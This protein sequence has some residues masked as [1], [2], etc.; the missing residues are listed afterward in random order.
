MNWVRA[1]KLIS[2]PRLRT[3]F[4]E[5]PRGEITQLA[6]WSAYNDAFAKAKLTRPLMQAKDFITNVS[7]TFT[8]AQ[9]RVVPNEQDPSR[10]K[11][12][13]GGVRPRAVPVD[14]RGRPY[15]RCLWRT[16]APST[17]GTT[18]NG[19]AHA[20]AKHTECDLSV[21]KPEELWDHV[22]TAH[23][24]VPKDPTTGKFSLP[25]NFAE[26]NPGKTWNCHWGGCK[27]FGHGGSQDVR[28]VFKH[29]QT[30]LP[31]TTLLAPIHRQHN[32]SV[33]AVATHPSH[34]S[35]LSGKGFLNTAVDERADA[36]GL[37]L[38]SVLVL[39]NLAR[40]MG[41]IDLANAGSS[42]VNALGGDANKGKAF[43]WVEKCFAP[44]RERLGFVMAWNHS[45]KEY[46]PALDGLIDRGLPPVGGEEKM[47]VD[48]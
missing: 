15:T 6:L 1:C 5:D 46:L 30:H 20:P 12:T 40:Q 10:P 28:Q 7:N 2:L 9:A 27:H 35:S 17:N 39:R 42:G 16:T 11:Y 29:V 37:P 34:A 45:L 48:P 26:Q 18:L 13:I 44:V 21:A 38:A 23:F 47:V 19:L 25:E 4:E 32:L 22:L 3:C 41:K 33:E 31:D 8:S 43:S 36:A 14:Q 24:S